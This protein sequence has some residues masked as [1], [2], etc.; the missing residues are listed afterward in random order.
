MA[1][2]VSCA[3]G[4]MSSS[5]TWKTLSEVTNGYI[6]SLSASFN[7]SSSISESESFILGA[8]AVDAV[9]IKI[10]A[11]SSTTPT[12]TFTVTLRNVSLGSDAASVTI[13]ASALHAKAEGWIVCKFS[14]SHTPSGA[15]LYS[16]R[17][18]RSVTDSSSNRITLY[19]STIDFINNARYMSR[20]VRLTTTAAP[21]SG[22]KLIVAGEF[23]GSSSTNSFTVTMNMTT[24][25]SVV[26]G[27]LQGTNSYGG[28]YGNQGLT[29]ND[30]GT[31]TF[32]T[33]AATNYLL[34][35]QNGIG[36][37]AGGILN[38]GTSGTPMPSSSTGVIKLFTTTTVDYG[39][40]VRR[41]GEMNGFGA[42]KTSWTHL[43]SDAAATDTVIEV[44]STSGWQAGDV[45]CFAPTSRTYT[46]SEH[47]TILSVDSATQV[48]LT[49]GLTNAHSGTSPT[50]AEVGNLTRNV[51]IRATDTSTMFSYF[52]VYNYSDTDLDQ[53]E[54]FRLGSGTSLKRGIEVRTANVPGS[55]N[56]TMTNCSAHEFTATNA[57]GIYGDISIGH[58][59]VENCVFYNIYGPSINIEY[60]NVQGSLD[61]VIDSCLVIKTTG[62]HGILI[63]AVE[64]IADN[65]VA[66]AFSNGFHFFSFFSGVEFSSSNIVTSGLIAH[67]NNGIGINLESPT[68]YGSEFTNCTAYRNNGAGFEIDDEVQRGVYDTI[69]LF[70]NNGTNLSLKGVLCSTFIDVVCDSDAAFGTDT[71]LNIGRAPGRFM[72]HVIFE[73]CTFGATEPHDSEDINWEAAQFAS[74]IFKD[75]LF[76][77]STFLTG[78][79]GMTKGSYLAS[80]RHNQTDGEHV[81][82]KKYGTL[83]TDSTI[84][85]GAAPSLRITPNNASNKVNSLGPKGGFFAKALNGQAP[86]ASIKVRLSETGDGEEYNGNFPRLIVKKNVNVGI[87]SDTVI[88]TATVASEGSFETLSGSTP[89]VTGDCTLEFYVDCDGDEG[90]INVDDFSAE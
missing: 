27:G 84:F 17:V 50:Q 51:K 89:T 65:V 34:E 64:T 13:N 28:T 66:G 82:Y 45:L 29:I 68:L 85:S 3:T 1:T 69:T 10:A 6:D 22:D 46:E 2:L 49:A 77:S 35:V 33:T 57:S 41:S 39:L 54:F 47:K 81:T 20:A 62:S 16:V 18:N 8:T 88:D 11:T 30:K 26:Y 19:A 52:T 32:G 72:N 4:N 80:Q 75:C 90:W 12:G 61:R 23:T 86:V 74:L 5:S 59:H 15:H 37:F 83:S 21:A 58:V 24:A 7:V 67:S 25:G 48:T 71:G 43:T 53:V 76:D 70:G 79:T 36:V 44:T 31:M 14:S 9:L 56:F 38:V 63:G 78:Q 60:P 55:S 42:T 73:N 40:E 87:N